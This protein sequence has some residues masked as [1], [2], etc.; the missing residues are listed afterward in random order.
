MCTYSTHPPSTARLHPSLFKLYLPL[1]KNFSPKRSVVN[2]GLMN[3][4]PSLIKLNV[5]PYINE[6]LKKDIAWFY[7]TCF[8]VDGCSTETD[9]RSFGKT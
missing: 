6:T 8:L 7:F 3:N 5:V 1:C 9:S 4:F 2:V